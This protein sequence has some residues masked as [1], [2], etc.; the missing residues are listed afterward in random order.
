MSPGLRKLGLTAHIASSVGW[1]GAVSA[2][3]ALAIGGLSS[4]DLQTARAAYVAMGWMTW[5]VIVPSAVASLFSGVIQSLGTP[6]GLAR[7]YWVVVKLAITVVVLLVLFLHTSPIDYMGVVA[8]RSM[9]SIASEMPVRIQLAVTSGAAVVA[10]LVAT[11]LGVYKP[12]GLTPWSR[13]R[14]SGATRQSN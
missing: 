3:L 12:R 14:P 7:H 4:N 2:F 9:V 1:L 11:G 8:Q 6:W 10:L 13:R 5:F